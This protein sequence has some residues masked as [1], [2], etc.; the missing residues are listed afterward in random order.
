[1]AGS[2]NAGGHSLRA[3]APSPTQPGPQRP[4]VPATTQQQVTKTPN[5]S[6]SLPQGSG[7][8]SNM[9]SLMELPSRPSLLGA[10]PSGAS[11]LLRS[12]QKNTYTTNSGPGRIQKRSFS[13]PDAKSSGNEQPSGSRSGHNTGRFYGPAVS[14]ADSNK[15]KVLGAYT[16]PARTY[17]EHRM[18]NQAAQAAAEQKRDSLGRG[19]QRNLLK[20]PAFQ[21]VPD[22]RK[23][24]L[25]GDQVRYSPSQGALHV[26]RRASLE[27]GTVR[28]KDRQNERNSSASSSSAAVIPSGDQLLLSPEKRLQFSN[29]VTK[30]HIMKLGAKGDNTEPSKP[31]T[32]AAVIIDSSEPDDDISGLLNDLPE[33][34]D[35]DRGGTNDGFRG[36]DTDVSNIESKLKGTILSN[37]TSSDPENE[38]DDL[39]EIEEVPVL[40][41]RRSR[42]QSGHDDESNGT[43]VKETV[44]K[45]LQNLRNMFGTV[46]SSLGVVPLKETES[47]VP[48]DDS[49]KEYSGECVNQKWGLPLI[50]SVRKNSGGKRQA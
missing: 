24:N 47:D 15:S 5:A 1:M 37:Q 2:N 13:Q 49:E 20:D 18:R 41:Q 9:P 21:G 39:E 22:S 43:V 10:G 50:G 26:P 29:L 36:M 40:S 48:A 33:E 25:S 32:K 19:F 11:T 28:G 6:S 42:N 38:F 27:H 8:K 17:Q 14:S 45:G 16:A 31:G 12:Q 46:P 4:N 34:T 23:R 44:Q 30:S 35:P 7:S 3:S